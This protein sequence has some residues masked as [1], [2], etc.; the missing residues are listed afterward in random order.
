VQCS[1]VR[2]TRRVFHFALN[3]NRNLEEV[4]RKY[5]MLGFTARDNVEFVCM[6]GFN[7]TPAQGVER[8][9]FLREPFAVTRG[10]CHMIFPVIVSGM[11]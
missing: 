7:T 6:Y 1:N 2:F 5:H 11:G 10:A 3:D 8:F 9:R 4:R